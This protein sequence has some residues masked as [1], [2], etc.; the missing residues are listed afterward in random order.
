MQV[1]RITSGHVPERPR[2]CGLR[3]VPN[4]AYE[5]DAPGCLRRSN[6]GDAIAP[7]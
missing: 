5:K 6:E 7:K 4:A 2:L 3:H 1:Q